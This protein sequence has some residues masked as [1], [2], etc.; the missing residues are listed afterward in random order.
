MT[1]H[2]IMMALDIPETDRSTLRDH[3]NWVQICTLDGAILGWYGT[4]KKLTLN[5]YNFRGRNV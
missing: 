5:V 1:T 4:T 2:T 3:R